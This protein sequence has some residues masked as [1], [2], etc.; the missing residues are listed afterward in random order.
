MIGVSLTRNA[1][2]C[3]LCLLLDAHPYQLK[4]VFFSFGMAV[5]KLHSLWQTFFWLER[6]NGRKNDNDWQFF[7]HLVL[8]RNSICH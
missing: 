2:P 1:F 5:N 3:G 7:S 6:K 8:P 4:D